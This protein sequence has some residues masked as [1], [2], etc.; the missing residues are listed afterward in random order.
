MLLDSGLQFKERKV[1]DK[2]KKKKLAK[3]ERTHHPS[4]GREKIA[5]DIRI[6]GH[7]KLPSK[8]VKAIS[9]DRPREM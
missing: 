8:T 7:D 9:I 5:H 3:R 1:N 6:T 2:K 4:V